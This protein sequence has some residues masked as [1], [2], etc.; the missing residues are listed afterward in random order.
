MRK[1]SLSIKSFSLCLRVFPLFRTIVKGLIDINE[2]LLFF[3]QFIDCI[4]IGRDLIR[5]LHNNS[6]YFVVSFLLLCLKHFHTFQHL[7]SAETRLRLI[8]GYLFQSI[9]RKSDLSS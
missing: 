4:G 6:R 1:Y 9:I 8:I 7:V 5:L 3:Y 2:D